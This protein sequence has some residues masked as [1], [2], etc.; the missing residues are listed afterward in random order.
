ME[1]SQSTPF[2]T[3]PA[4]P[5]GWRDS[6]TAAPIAFDRY[7]LGGMGPARTAPVVR[8]PRISLWRRLRNGTVLTV[9]MLGCYAAMICGLAVFFSGVFLTT[10]H[11]LTGA[12]FAKAAPR[13][14]HEQAWQWSAPSQQQFDVDFARLRQQGSIRATW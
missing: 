13:Y 10:E 8:P 6:G 14:A 9:L 3:A 1:H 5:E 7:H 4:A 2:R 11:V 12:A